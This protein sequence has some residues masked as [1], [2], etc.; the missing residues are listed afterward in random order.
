MST[1]PPP[2]TNPA[3]FVITSLKVAQLPSSLLNS[4]SLLNSVSPLTS[5]SPLNSIGVKGLRIGF[6][7]DFRIH[8][9]AAT[10]SSRDLL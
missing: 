10:V 6:V 7:A 2:K 5:V 8:L 9:V 4:I 1:L 3:F